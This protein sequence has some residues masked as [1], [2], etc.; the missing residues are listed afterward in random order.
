MT[1]E[2]TVLWTI[3]ND[4]PEALRGLAAD[5]GYEFPLILDP[6]AMTIKAYGVLNEGSERGIPHPTAVIVDKQGVVRYVRI[7]E[8]YRERPSI[9]ELMEALAGLQ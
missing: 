8:N 1:G 4:D 9:E 5:A 7:D 3:V 2:D 6:N